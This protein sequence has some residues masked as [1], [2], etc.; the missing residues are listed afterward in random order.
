GARLLVGALA[1]VG[2]FVSTWMTSHPM[3]VAEVAYPFL[4]LL[5]VA[6]ARADGNAQPPLASP[7]VPSRAASIA[8]RRLS[9]A[10]RPL[11][12]AGRPLLIA[13]RPLL[14]AGRPLSIVGRP[15]R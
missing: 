14:I 1:G 11:L 8:G 10:G 3:L 15:F 9:I 12:I 2:A 4:M 5:G 7:D 13:G 6:L